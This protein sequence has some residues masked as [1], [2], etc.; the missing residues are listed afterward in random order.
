LDQV[1][2]ALAV[3]KRELSWNC[4]PYCYNYGWGSKSYFQWHDEEQLKAAKIFHYHDAMYAHFWSTFIKCLRETHPPVAEWLA[5]L[6]PLK[7][8]APLQWRVTQKILQQV[9]SRKQL[10]YEKSCRVV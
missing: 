7:N 8:E 6:G 2:L 4:L 10:A 1:A 5:S 9:R 3:V